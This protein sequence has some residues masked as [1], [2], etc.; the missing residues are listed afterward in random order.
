MAALRQQGVH[1]TDAAAFLDTCPEIEF[2]VWISCG[3]GQ[4]D[5][6]QNGF[7]VVVLDNGLDNGAGIS[8]LQAE[9]PWMSPDLP[10]LHALMMFCHIFVVLSEDSPCQLW[11]G[12]AIC[13]LLEISWTTST[14]ESITIY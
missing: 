2:S 9:A 5:H 11:I 13:D 8:L 4:P 7:A 6:W 1:P 3:D 12:L 14:L 10:R